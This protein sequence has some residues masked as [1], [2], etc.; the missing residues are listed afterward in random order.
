MKTRKSN[1]KQRIKVFRDLQLL[2]A[3]F[4]LTLLSAYY[5]GL[6]FDFERFRFYIV[7]WIGVGI[8]FFIRF[9]AFQEEMTLKTG[10]EWSFLG[11][12]VLYLVNIPWSA[13]KGL[14]LREF[15]TYFTF[16][17]FFIVLEQISFSVAL[18]KKKWFLFG[19]GVSA[20][21]L[22]LLSLFYHFG[23]VPGV[24]LP[25][26]MSLRELFVA[27][28]IFSNFQYPNTA[29][30]YFSMA[31]FGML[32]F[33]LLEEKK[34]WRFTALF[35]SFLILEGIF[36]TYSRGAFLI[37]P[38]TLLFLLW[39]LP[40]REKIRL[41]L[42]V[43][44]SVAILLAFL[45][46]LE[47]YLFGMRYAAFLALFFG[48]ALLL[49]G[50]GE[51]ALEYEEKMG[52]LSNRFYLF[53]GVG[54][55]V[56]G[57]FVFLLGKYSN[58]LPLYL[59]RRI[60]NINFSDPNVVGRFT[61]YRDALRIGLDRP[62]NGWGG[63]GWKVLYFGYQSAPYFTESTHNFYAQLFVEGGFLGILLVVG[64][65][66]FLFWETWKVRDRLS[67]QEAIFTLGVL[68]MLF[69]GF[70]HGI[71]DINFSL[72]SYHF[73]VWFFAGV[74]GGM[75]REKMVRNDRWRL[76]PRVLSLS[77]GWGFLLS[78]GFLILVSLMA[79]GVEQG[80]VGEYLL[81][82]GDVHNAIAFYQDAARFD[83]LNAEVHLGLSQAFRSLFLASGDPQWRIA[84]EKEAQRAYRLSPFKHTYVEHLALLHVERGDFEKGL[85][86]FE[87]A[88]SR[89]PLLPVM[90]E[91]LAL[92]FKSVGDFY[93]K[94]G[95]KDKAREFYQRGVKVE[96]LFRENTRRSLRPVE[97]NGGVGKVVLELKAL[98]ERE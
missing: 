63:G 35:F 76:F 65:L 73:V 95:E 79:F 11:L 38:L 20:F 37:V 23:F 86:L 32:T 51:L 21:I 44:V 13:D 80:M 83:P 39:I 33:V 40:R 93:W 68:G 27:G 36:F 18:P 55:G 75:V 5:R 14:A 4:L 43:V 64:L 3:F 74:L 52:T 12:V 57:V 24:V 54:L 62:L 70:A 17:V 6:Y 48:G 31:Y 66:F 72:G 8:F 45:S 92:T 16:F 69:M 61:F 2:W 49:A 81:K 34:H 94:R 7:L 90:Y 96:E 42:L 50:V 82:T 26:Y 58:L 25:T 91:H 19:F 41:F 97:G 47:E 1:P 71:L 30:A 77:S 98:L 46:P 15:L 89:A 88:V 78:V 87:E 85:A 59:T 10:V 53:T 84:S 9:F 29:A 60:Q 56:A 28:R 67:P 22:I